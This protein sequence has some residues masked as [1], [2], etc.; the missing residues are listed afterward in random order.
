MAFNFFKKNEIFDSFPK[1]EEVARVVL[2]I[3]PSPANAER[4]FSHAHFL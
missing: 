1:L 4:A 2:S 3:L